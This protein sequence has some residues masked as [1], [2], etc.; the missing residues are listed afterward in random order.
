MERQY[1]IFEILPDGAPL[2]RVTV[3]GHE[4]AVSKLQELA[5]QTQNEVRII[6]I[7]TNTLIAGMNVPKP[8]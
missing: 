3:S 4:N 8:S 1:D 2:W 5:A 6:H 7:P